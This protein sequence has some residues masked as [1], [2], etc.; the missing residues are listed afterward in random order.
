MNTYGYVGGNPLYSID[1]S[2]LASVNYDDDVPVSTRNAIERN[3]DLLEQAL[4]NQTSSCSGATDNFLDSFFSWNITVTTSGSPAGFAGSTF[5][6]RNSTT[7]F[8]G[9][10][11]L[12]DL[13]HE[14]YHTTP[15]NI[16]RRSNRGVVDSSS[17][18]S[19]NGPYGAYDFED[20]V[21]NGDCLCRYSTGEQTSPNPYRDHDSRPAWQRFFDRFT[22]R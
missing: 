4:I 8:G 5:G 15:E 14:F 9:R 3:L 13:A 7:I 12:G 20:S 1:P 18:P 11:S 2:G 6:R 21:N 10:G 17:A 22:S 16:N 19:E